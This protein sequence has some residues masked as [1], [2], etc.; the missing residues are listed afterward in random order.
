L[1]PT[2]LHPRQTRPQTIARPRLVAQLEQ[3]VALPLTLVLGPAGA[4][5]STA[6]V[7]WLEHTE[8]PV[9]WLSLDPADDAPNRFLAYVVAALQT[10]EPR[11]QAD[12][13]ALLAAPP[14]DDL[15]ALWAD[16]LVIPL[17]EREHPPPLL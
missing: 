13:A 3:C 17:A 12:A 9:A 8:L 10:I 5:K 1:L 11:L 6:V 4:G 7:A 15:E 2:K 16:T 14:P